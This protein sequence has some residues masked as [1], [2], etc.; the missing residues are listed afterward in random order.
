MYNTCRIVRAIS[1]LPFCS[2]WIFIMF[3]IFIVMYNDYVDTFV[4][5]F[6]TYLFKIRF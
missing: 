3:L 6:S 5:F 2:Y 1:Y 4:V